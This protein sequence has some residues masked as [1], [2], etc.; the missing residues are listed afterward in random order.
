MK[1]RHYLLRQKGIS[2]V[3]DYLIRDVVSG[4]VFRIVGTVLGMG[5]TLSLQNMEGAEVLKLH[6]SMLFPV[7]PWEISRDDTVA[8]TVA[9]TYFGAYESWEGDGRDETTGVTAPFPIGRL[10]KP[11][12]SITFP[13]APEVVVKGDVQT[14]LF[15]YERN[16]RSIA[17]VSNHWWETGEDFNSI[18]IADGEDNV[19]IL[20]C[21]VAIDMWVDRG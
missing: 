15:T 8:A 13:L 10:V 12:F 20:A 14:R 9:R 6:Q 3:E 19:M 4:P 5:H 17:A 2:L 16:G 21:A 7:A 11:W 18:E 1:N